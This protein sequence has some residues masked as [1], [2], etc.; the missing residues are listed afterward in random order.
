MLSLTRKTDY[1]LVALAYLGQR[2]QDGQPPVSAR[3]IAQMFSLPAPMLTNI[4][5]DLAHGRLVVSTR[6]AQGGYHLASDPSQVR[7]SEVI[8]AVDGPLRLA[9]CTDGLPIV[10]QGCDLAHTCPVREPIRRLH[11]RLGA[12]FD[13]VTLADLLDNKTEVPVRQVGIQRR[14]PVTV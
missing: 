7:L 9:A 3:R 1:A 10:G 5:K 4:L 8:L 12:F 2:H 6:G 11:E 13:N 14:E